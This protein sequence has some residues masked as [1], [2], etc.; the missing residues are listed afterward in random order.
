MDLKM[1]ES[2]F[3]AGSFHQRPYFYQKGTPL[4]NDWAVSTVPSVLPGR[5]PICP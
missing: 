4:R 3:P 1:G 2:S 5:R